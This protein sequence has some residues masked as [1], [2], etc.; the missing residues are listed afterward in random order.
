MRGRLERWLLTCAERSETFCKD[1]AHADVDAIGN[2]VHAKHKPFSNQHVI[3]IIKSSSYHQYLQ[4][5]A[6][7]WCRV[8]LAR[9][10]RLDLRASDTHCSAHSDWHTVHLT[11]TALQYT[12]H[13]AHS[14]LCVHTVLWNKTNLTKSL[15]SETQPFNVQ[16]PITCRVE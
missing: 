10:Q 16:R 9:L 13:S 8:D 1:T 11:H 3:V 12:L 14:A 6:V 4:H 7:K 15:F 2:N 5:D